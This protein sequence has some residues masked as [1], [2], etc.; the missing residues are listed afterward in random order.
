MAR[1]LTKAEAASKGWFCLKDLKEQFRLKPA[2]GQRPAGSVW[3]GQGAYKVY[4]KVLCVPMRS[5]CKPSDA[6]LK[7]LA[8]ARALIG[9]RLCMQCGQ[10]ANIDQVQGALCVRCSDKQRV[11]QC[12]AVAASWIESEA[13]YLDAETTGLEHDD[14]IIEICLIS[15]AGDVLMNSLVR[16]TKAIPDDAISIHGIT[17][18][19][20]AGAPSWEAL[21]G[22]FCRLIENKVVVIYNSDFDVR[23]LA[24]TAS[25]YRL[26]APKIQ[27]VC[28]MKLYAR[29]YGEERPMGKYQWQR[30]SD[31]AQQC[32]I[33]VSGAHRAYA[34]CLM[35]RGVVGHM[36]RT[37]LRNESE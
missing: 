17:N 15:Q 26:D 31:A 8:D 36:A 28:A 34:D 25:R 21:H 2:A 20:V 5:Y 16:P 22:E 7:S 30:L 10:R 29:W 12:A 3:Q 19:A 14:E 6:Q 37:T 11:R 33:D 4:D 23:L 18:E 13:I 27:G 24:Q 1:H 35:T 32:G 9:T